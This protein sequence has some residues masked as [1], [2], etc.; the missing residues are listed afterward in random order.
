MA[1]KKM[2]KLISFIIFSLF[3]PTIFS[4]DI[5]STTHGLEIS[6][7]IKPGDIIEFK[8]QVNSI[9]NNIIILN[10][11]GGDSK[12]AIQIGMEISKH[13]FAVVVNNICASSCANYLFP[14]GKWKIIAEGGILIW[15]GSYA[16]ECSHTAH[17][18]DSSTA[19][20]KEVDEYKKTI[21]ELQT[22]NE[23]YYRKINVNPRITCLTE[24][25][26]AAADAITPN[27]SGFTLTTEAIKLF[28]VK[29]LVDFRRTY[30]RPDME[31]HV[32]IVNENMIIENIEENNRRRQTR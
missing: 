19:T 9:Q 4:A 20:K 21:K 15:H 24:N 10:S 14:A 29:N 27:S 28:G 7:E 17:K 5:K 11:P 26:K 31:G 23:H 2:Q 1:H 22:L 25:I 6:G 8:K 18:I 12:S 3:S 13:S 32:A 16:S 30:I